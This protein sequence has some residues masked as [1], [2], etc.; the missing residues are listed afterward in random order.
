MP[1]ERTNLTQRLSRIEVRTEKETY[2]QLSQTNKAN[3]QDLTRDNILGEPS[4]NTWVA[5]SQ[6]STVKPDV[7][8]SDSLQCSRVD[9][10]FAAQ[11]GLRVKYEAN[12]LPIRVPDAPE[13]RA[14]A[15]PLIGE[16]NKLK[17]QKTE[18][19]K[20]A[21]HLQAQELD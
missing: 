13:D 4:T 20:S 19:V 21:R 10:F 15:L 17:T 14:V 16:I 5:G 9:G 2:T 1:A 8:S 18:K 7:V 6:R 12:K 11:D 3:A